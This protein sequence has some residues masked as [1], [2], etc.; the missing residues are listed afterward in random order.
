M[1]RHDLEVRARDAA[2]TTIGFCVLGV[3]HLQVKRRELTSDL[4][5]RSRATGG[6]V[7]KAGL[8]QIAGT[9]E[10]VVE[11]LLDSV[12]KLLPGSARLAVQQSRTA[13]KVLRK[14]IL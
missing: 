9:A 10:R 7:A 11:P 1:D 6:G 3:Q 4:A 14:V 12:E 8:G 5:G 2:Y 13:A